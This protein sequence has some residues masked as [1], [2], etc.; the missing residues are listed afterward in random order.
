MSWS[1]LD[2]PHPYPLVLPVVYNGKVSRLLGGL[3]SSYWGQIGV[4][5]NYQSIGAHYR[6]CGRIR[7]A[8]YQL[9]GHL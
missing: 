1:F 2:H 3:K 6:C 4:E 7:A 9:K 5:L 8:H